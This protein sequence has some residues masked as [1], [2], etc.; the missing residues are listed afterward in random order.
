M[1]TV[2]QTREEYG[3]PTGKTFYRVKLNGFEIITGTARLERTSL[4]GYVVRFHYHASVI[5]EAR[6]DTLDEAESA[7]ENWLS[8]LGC[9]LTLAVDALPDNE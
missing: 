1:F 7:A 5:F 3:K 2:E 8:E 4:E 9:S 6:R